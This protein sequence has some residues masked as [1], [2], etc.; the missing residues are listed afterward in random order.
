MLFGTIEHPSASIQDQGVR[1]LATLILQCTS[2]YNSTSDGWLWQLSFLNIWDGVKGEGR[3][4]TKDLL[5]RDHQRRVET[6]KKGLHEKGR[7][8]SQNAEMWVCL[9]GDTS[10][11]SLALWCL[12]TICTKFRLKIFLLLMREEAPKH[13]PPLDPPSLT[14]SP[15][16]S[17]SVLL[18]IV[19]WNCSYF[20]R[21]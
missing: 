20:F 2:I 9:L 17:S 8:G 12:R 4:P 21:S 5:I 14:L 7:L 13:P 3:V 18:S 15:L 11:L 16:P 1:L 10:I 19:S 6:C